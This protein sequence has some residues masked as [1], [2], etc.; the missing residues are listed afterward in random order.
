MTSSDFPDWRLW[1]ADD[2]RWYATR[3]G[4]QFP[5][6]L[7]ALSEQQLREKLAAQI[8]KETKR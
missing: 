5:R 4:P 1:E 7:D 6:T 3:T 2:G 8:A